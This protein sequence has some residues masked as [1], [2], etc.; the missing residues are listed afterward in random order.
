MLV[1]SCMLEALHMH[2]YAQSEF[3][4]WMVMC[5][6]QWIAEGQAC[7]GVTGPLATI[8]DKPWVVQQCAAYIAPDL[9]TQQQ[10]LQYGLD[11]TGQHCQPTDLDDAAQG[12]PAYLNVCRLSGCSHATWPST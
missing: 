1:L 8:Q 4:F 5:R 2:N 9:A 10:V 6:S 11:I 7:G 12:K 3:Q